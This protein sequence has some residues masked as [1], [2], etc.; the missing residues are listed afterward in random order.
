MVLAVFMGEQPTGGYRIEVAG[1]KTGE[2]E[3]VVQVRSAKPPP[4]AITT[5]VLTQPFFL[6]AVP[7]SNLVVKF[8][9][10]PASK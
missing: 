7:R 5:E 9:P 1:V 3:L 2:R 4:G 6:A 10:A 8:V